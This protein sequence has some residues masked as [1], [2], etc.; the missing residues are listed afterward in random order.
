MGSSFIRTESKNVLDLQ[1]IVTLKSDCLLGQVSKQPLRML[2]STSMH[3]RINIDASSGVYEV[4][5]PGGE[6][7]MQE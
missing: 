7:T 4:K 1:F 3:R 5:G 6:L 2:G